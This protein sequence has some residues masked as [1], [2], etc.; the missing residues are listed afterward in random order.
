MGCVAVFAPNHF[1][2]IPSSLL[3]ARAHDYASVPTPEAGH[4][5]TKDGVLSV[6]LPVAFCE[7]ART[8][9]AAATPIQC[10]IGSDD[11]DG[12]GGGQR[13]SRPWVLLHVHGK[14]CSILCMRL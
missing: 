6:L 14:L 12:G 11:S 4:E 8:T 2:C 5:L 13:C 3:P 9:A 7:R 1:S 10:G